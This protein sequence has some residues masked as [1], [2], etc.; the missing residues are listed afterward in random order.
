MKIAIVSAFDTYE[1]RIEQLYSY[2]IERGD[3]VKIFQADFS[4]RDKEKRIEERKDTVWI[5]TRQYKKNLS[6]ARMYSHYRLSKDVFARLAEEEWELLWVILPPNFFAKNIELYRTKYSKVKIVFDIMDMWPETMPFGKL[7]ALP[8]M[9]MWKN[10]RNKNLSKADVVVTECQLFG[11]IIKEEVNVDTECIYLSRKYQE[12]LSNYQNSSG[13][14]SL[15]YLGSINN[16]IDIKLIEDIIVALSKRK[17]VELHIIG[18]G[19]KRKE[20]IE[21]SERAG[22][23]VHYHGIIYDFKEKLKIYDRCHFGLNIMKNTVCVG[24]TMK[25]MDYYEAGL[26]IINNIQGD[27]W[28]NIEK[29]DLGFNISANTMEKFA[30]MFVNCMINHKEF[31][32]M[33]KRVR[34]FY[35]NELTTQALAKKMDKVMS[36]LE[37]S[38]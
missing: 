36:V 23:I 10:L 28:I 2:F 21:T 34:G 16:I 14:I 33:R 11:K 38:K 19:E 6:V 8:I 1:V 7:K 24:M 29:K 4:H 12:N 18:D 26:P 20:L 35:E 15:C 3:V 27:T 5:K 25:S 37:K 31:L 9:K 13:R 22:A 30:D 32:E 17:S